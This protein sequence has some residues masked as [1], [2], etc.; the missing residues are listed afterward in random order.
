MS[1]HDAY[2]LSIASA[3]AERATCD[4]AHVGCLLVQDG[5]VISTGFNGSPVG[6]PHC[7]AVG[8]QMENGHCIRTVHA[9]ANAIIQAALHGV[10]TRGATCYL[11]HF[12]CCNCAKMLIN[13][14]VVRVVFAKFYGL[15]LKAF[16]LL[17]GSNI[18]VDCV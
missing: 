9:E 4:R 5:H 7:D 6:Q 3:V 11:T 12:P 18:E 10:S 16:W 13:A 14:G 1:E 2:F 8:H 17:T 15:D